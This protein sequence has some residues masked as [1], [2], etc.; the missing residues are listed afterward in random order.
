MKK[1]WKRLIDV[2]YELCDPT[3]KPRKITKIGYGLA[4]M[5]FF[6]VYRMPEIAIPVL[7]AVFLV[8][9]CFKIILKFQDRRYRKNYIEPSHIQEPS[10]AT[11]ITEHRFK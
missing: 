4:F 1:Q 8:F 5:S 6:L 2:W 7:L 11:R 10:V 9:L 3:Y